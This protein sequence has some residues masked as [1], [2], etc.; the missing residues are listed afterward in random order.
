MSSPL[1]KPISSLISHFEHDHFTPKVSIYN[2]TK[3]YIQDLQFYGFETLFQTLCYLKE[4]IKKIVKTWH[5]RSK[6][7]L[8][9]CASKGTRVAHLNLNFNCQQ[10]IQ[11]IQKEHL[12]HKVIVEN[13][14]L[15]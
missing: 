15:T 13:D 5:W 8:N 7:N 11:P 14:T 6:S 3:F 10:G 4:K 1:F 12:E 2:L 9:L